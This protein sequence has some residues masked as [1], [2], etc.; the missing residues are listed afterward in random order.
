MDLDESYEVAKR[1]VEEATPDIERIESE[2]DTKLRIITRIITEALGWSHSD[3]ASERPNENGYSDYVVSDNNHPAFVVEAKR[4]G[5]LDLATQARTRQTYKIS[6][7]A[8]KAAQTA[9]SQVASYCNPLGIPLA[10][11]TDG[12]TW[13]VFIPYTPGSSYRDKKAVVFPGFDALLAGFAEFY[14][15]LSKVGIRNREYRLVFD[16]LHEN[17]LIQS[18]P[19]V[20]AYPLSDILVEQKSAIAFDLEKVFTSFFS[21]LAGDGDQ[22]LLINCFVESRESRIADF[23][24]ERI[25]ANVLGNINPKD[26]SVDEGLHSLI[27]HA[28]EGE[29]GQTVFIVGPSGAGKTTFLDRFFRK[30]LARSIREQCIVL[31]VNALDAT[32]DEQT[33]VSWMRERIIKAIE[34]QI[35]SEGFP[36]WD[37]LLSLY[38]GEYTKRAKG[39]D[40]KLYEK[41]K[42]AFRIKFGEYLDQMVREDREGYLSR[43]LHEITRNRKKLPIFVIDNTDEFSMAFKE[44]IFQ[45]FQALRRASK[46]CLLIF[47][48]TDRSAWAFSKTEIFNIYSSKSFYLPTPSPREVFRRRVNYLKEKLSSVSGYKNKV[49]Y[50]TERGIRISI[51]NLNAFAGVVESIFV[52]QDY[53]AKRIGELSNYNMRKTLNL[54][55][56]VITSSV[57]RIEDII[58]SYITG[59]LIAPSSEKFMNA[60][61]KGD[62]SLFRQGDIND[63]FPLFQV[64]SRIRQSPLLHIRILT[65]LRDMHT[66]ASEDAERYVPTRSLYSF[67]DLMSCPE[68]AVEASLVALLQSGLIEPYDLSKKDYSQDQKLAITFSGLS[69]LEL[70]LF[71]SVF[72]EQM[73]LTT[74]ISDSDTAL[75]IRSVAQSKV[76]MQ[77]RLEQVRGLF[78]AFLV[79]EDERNIT[80][81]LSQEFQNQFLLRTNISAQWGSSENKND[82]AASVSFSGLAASCVTA[83]VD[84]FNHSKNWGFVNVPSLKDRAFIHSS[85]LK[86]GGFPDVYEGDQVLCDISRGPKGLIVSAVYEVVPPKAA[87]Y[88]ARIIKLVNDRHFGF[89]HV[90][91]TGMDALFHFSQFPASYLRHLRDGLDLTVEIRTEGEGRTL[92]RRVL[93]Y[94]N[95]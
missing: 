12:F 41:D 82:L 64:D 79:R 80:V 20:A 13:I 23:S 29:L 77:E 63:I 90:G 31:N 53:A 43:L 18:T 37:E 92:V 27:Q 36:T 68:S 48:A 16:K 1:I 4:L 22:D 93:E 55:R 75:K 35:F 45:Y 44:N 8:L 62:Y 94:P 70:A 57:L 30:T 67:F 40:A 6:G 74:R 24:L 38:H 91:E 78:A 39:I 14:D 86:K 47:P 42:E 49:S 2:E 56:R 52:D 72:F 88:R 69:H 5:L 34:L 61:L 28:V 87:T 33:S 25:T 11:V 15:L 85:I 32:G 60:L 81:P 7:P 66:V 9:I 71:N 50:F 54:S 95:F 19:L 17:R 3:I 59:D 51:D 76:G 89:V 73:A 83:N 10:V 58:R 65:L 84:T 21:N 26:K 46:H